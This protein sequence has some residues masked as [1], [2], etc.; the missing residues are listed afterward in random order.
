MNRVNSTLFFFFTFAVGRT[1]TERS[2]L[3]ADEIGAR[4][5]LS[6]DAGPNGVLFRSGG[7]CQLPEGQTVVQPREVQ[8]RRGQ[9]ADQI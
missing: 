1:T 9:G 4:T 5:W 6:Q 2:V 8:R 7:R 3:R